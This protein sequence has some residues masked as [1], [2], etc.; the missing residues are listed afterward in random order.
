VDAILL[1]ISPEQGRNEAKQK[2]ECF[3]SFMVIRNS[4]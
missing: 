3:R 1:A 2:S 4:T